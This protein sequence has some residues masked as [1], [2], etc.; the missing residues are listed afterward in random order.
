[1]C[2]GRGV[3]VVMVCVGGRVVLVCR[4]VVM[5][6]VCVCVDGDGG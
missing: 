3:K 6:E 5:M 4:D 1:M 2:V